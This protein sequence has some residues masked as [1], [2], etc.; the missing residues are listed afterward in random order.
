MARR[1]EMKAV[2]AS[3]ISS[4]VVAQVV[5][6][7]LVSLLL[8]WLHVSLG[9]EMRLVDA[10]LSA[11]VAQAV[12]LAFALFLLLWLHVS[13]GRLLIAYAPGN[14]E[15]DPQ[16]VSDK[17]QR[18]TL[19]VRQHAQD[20]SNGSNDSNGSKGSNGSAGAPAD[21]DPFSAAE[22]SLISDVHDK[23]GDEQFRRVP[24]DLLAQFVRSAGHAQPGE[25]S[26]AER[27]ASML[28]W[29]G[30]SGVDGVVTRPPA[31]REDYENLMPAGVIGCDRDGRPIVLERPGRCKRSVLNAL[32]SM[33]AED[34]VR[35]QCVSKECIR[36]HMGA[37]SLRDSKRIY[38]FVSVID[39][40]TLGRHHFDARN[41]ALFK[42]YTQTISANY[43]DCLDRLYI[44]NA[45]F[46]M[47]ALWALIK[48]MLHPVTAAKVTILG[49]D[50]APALAASGLEIS[51]GRLPRDDELE[52][53]VKSA[54]RL[55]REAE[56]EGCG[57]CGGDGTARDL[58][59]GFLPEADADAI[60][61]MIQTKR[62]AQRGVGG[63]GSGVGGGG[64][65]VGGGG[66][67]VR[68]AVGEVYVEGST[69]RTTA[70]GGCDV[71]GR[72]DPLEGG[73]WSLH[74]ELQS[75]AEDAAAWLNKHVAPCLGAPSAP[76]APHEHV[77]TPGRAACRSPSRSPSQHG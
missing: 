34:F 77:C 60:Q 58:P 51:G 19:P 12:P 21:W 32:D 56:R 65:G 73:A 50:Y 44:V 43:P 8:A 39:V 47:S 76:T 24:L 4:A 42:E 11:V 25:P 72:P 16:Q 55:L 23:L 69:P 62:A 28:A 36:H 31:G 10:S 66:G 75:A 9:Q 17:R 48:P 30:R 33:T 70:E 18:S 5:P 3:Y 20:G 71:L 40:G 14:N 74:L 22:L 49:T 27:V 52:G 61:R 7:A 53:W 67:D 29:R 63:G 59:A 26:C 35:Q 45:P 2:D 57:G 46:L 13:L 1:E 64:S 37:A 38:K 68:G 6:L 15:Q 41:L 54:Q